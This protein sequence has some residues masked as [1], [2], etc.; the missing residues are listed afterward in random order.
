VPGAVAQ[1]A[2]NLAGMVLSGTATL[3]VQRAVWSRV[4]GASRLAAFRGPLR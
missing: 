2:I 3:L 4:Q 1:L